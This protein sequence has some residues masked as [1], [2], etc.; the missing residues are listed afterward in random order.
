MSQRKIILFGG[1]FDPVHLGHTT[2]ASSAVQ[3]IA[4]EK[5][6]FIPA[7]QS[8][9]KKIAPISTSDDRMNM[10][11]LAIAGNP[12]FSVSDYELKK[13]GANYTIETVR[14]FHQQLGSDVS[15]HWLTGADCLAELSHWYLVSDLLDECNLSVMYRAGCD[16]PDF[17]KFQALWGAERIKKLQNNIVKT[18]LVDISSTNIR[19]LL[20]SSLDV[21]SMLHPAVLDYINKNGLYKNS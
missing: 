17:T 15:L 7:K 21:N 8:P 10:I 19:R 4:A 1:T 9:L 11:A 3:Q 2:V 13:P 5:L 6:I 20:S 16:K 12:K 14:H 18:P